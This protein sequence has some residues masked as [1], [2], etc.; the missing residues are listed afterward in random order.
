MS[1]DYPD[2]IQ[3]ERAAQAR[4]SFAGSMPL[5]RMPRVLDLLAE[6]DSVHSGAIDFS[7]RFWLDD[8]RNVRADCALNGHVPL[9]CQRTLRPY[10]QPIES[11]ASLAIIESEDRLSILPED[12]EPKVCLDGQLNVAELI[13]DELIL[14]LPL[15]PVDPASEPMTKVGNEWDEAVEAPDAHPFADLANFRKS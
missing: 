9:Q 10:A 7:I 6:D 5:N 2:W 13:E 11:T 15:V 1:R 12:L 3:P 14:A 4:R 8:Q